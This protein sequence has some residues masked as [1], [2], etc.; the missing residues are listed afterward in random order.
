MSNSLLT[1][2]MITRKSLEIL[3]NNLVLTRNV[4][5]AYDDS[6]AVEGAKIGS[7]LRIRLPDRALVLT[8]LPCKCKTTTSNTQPWLY[9]A[10]N[11]LVLTSPLLN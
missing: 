10:K 9:L 5:R 7:T 6:F 2:D 8:V 4:N 11:T 1:I 3:E